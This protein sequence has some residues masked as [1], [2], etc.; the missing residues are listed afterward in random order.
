MPELPEVET[1]RR[2]LESII[3]GKIIKDVRLYYDGFVKYP[4]RDAFTANLKG[5]EVL[6]TGRRGKYL[7]LHLSQDMSLVIHLR[8]TGRILYYPEGTPPLTHTRGVFVFAG[9]EELHFH[10][11]RKFGT[12]W[13]I[14]PA[15]LSCITGLKALGPE[16]L[17]AKFSVDFLCRQ[18]QK[19]RSPI[20][21]LLLSQKA[22]AGIGNIYAD[23]ALFR[24]GVNPKR[25][26]DTLSK[27]EVKRLW[28][29]IREVLQEGLDA[30][31]TSMRDYLDARGS[32]GSFQDC[33]KVY[34]HK[35]KPC[36]RC[37]CI[38]EREKIAG[39]SSHYCPACQRQE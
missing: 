23:E 3:Q 34:G 37:G 8:M 31:G 33:L 11:V 39:R 4:G 5:K 32:S 29:G 25:P 17:E 24:A 6:G 18:C 12:M 27:K 22:A 9:G 2:D 35:G 15:T 7:F 21:S 13:L 30:R 38:I 14:S 1:I 10:D 28:S 36:P 20:K 16:P 19:T 26:C